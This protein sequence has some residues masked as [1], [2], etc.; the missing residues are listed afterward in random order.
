MTQVALSTNEFLRNGNMEGDCKI[1]VHTGNIANWNNLK[2]R[3]S[4]DIP[5]NELYQSLLRIFGKWSEVS[6][7][8]GQGEV[9]FL[10]KIKKSMVKY[11]D[12]ILV[13]DF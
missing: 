3:R 8:L 4:N 2:T 1:Y 6:G 5:A 7:P 13:S 12:K 11:T 10:L 9:R